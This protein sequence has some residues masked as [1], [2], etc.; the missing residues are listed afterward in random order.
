MIRSELI[1]RMASRFPQLMED[2][3]KCAVNE[4]LL[5][6]QGALVRGERVEF[7]DFGTFCLNYRSGRS[8]RN[9]KTGG[10][11]LVPAKFT[12]HF[13]AGKELKKRVLPSA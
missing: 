12:P 3:A 9:P 5:A 11:V 6:I 7:R 2:D 8:A 1:E 4:I 10:S 13:K